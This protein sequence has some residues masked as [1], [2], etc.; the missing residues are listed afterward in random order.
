[1]SDILT[2]PDTGIGFYRISDPIKN[3]KV[4]IRLEK[5]SSINLPKFQ[6]DDDQTGA[7]E[8]VFAWQEKVLS[9]R[10]YELYSGENFTPSNGLEQRYK[11]LSKEGRKTKRLFSYVDHDA[12]VGSTKMTP[13]ASNMT[14]IIE[15]DER[16][17]PVRQRGISRRLEVDYERKGENTKSSASYITM[18][19]MADLNAAEE[20]AIQGNEAILCTIKHYSNNVLSMKPNFNKGRQNYRVNVEGKRSELFEY[21]IEHW[22]KQPSKQ[23]EEKEKRMFQSIYNRRAENLKAFVGSSGFDGLPPNSLRIVLNGE[24]L[25]AQNFEYS[26]VYV[27]YFLELPTG[28]MTTNSLD[29]FGTTC[30]CS[31]KKEGRGNIA[32][33]SHPFTIELIYTPQRL[34]KQEYFPEWPELFFE[35]ISYDSWQRF[36]TEGYTSVK[37]PL[38][39]GKTENQLQCWRPVGTSIFTSLRRF[40]IGGTA[41]LEDTTYVSKPS[42]F[43][44]SHLSRYGFRTESTGDLNV[45]LYAVHQSKAAKDKLNQRTKAWNLAEKM[46]AGTTQAA[47]IFSLL[48]AYKRAKEAMIQAREHL[49]KDYDTMKP[50]ETSEW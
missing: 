15:N 17:A 40:F 39:P 32:H 26:G 5:A 27:N 29:L 14:E 18:Y 13:L 46:G 33:F 36:R 9:R 49:I 22:S 12:F 23:E 44:G 24:I 7:E 35:I 28:W 38:K 1:M 25:S 34:V 11:S 8:Y 37:V 50:P 6:S 43:Q 3:L 4:R 2:E 10:E 45:R 47:D 30:T 42:T 19:I 20:P 48:E 21:T 41:E 31:L 16:K